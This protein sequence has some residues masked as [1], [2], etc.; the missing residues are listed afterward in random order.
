MISTNPQRRSQAVYIAV[1]LPAGIK[2]SLTQAEIKKQFYCAK[3]VHD[4][5][6]SCLEAFI[7]AEETFSIIAA[8]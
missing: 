1:C 8:S 2:F 7:Y 6:A 4:E 5:A 3:D